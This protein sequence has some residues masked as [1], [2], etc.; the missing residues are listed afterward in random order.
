MAKRKTKRNAGRLE[1]RRGFKIR[2]D[3]MV[4]LAEDGPLPDVHDCMGLTRAHGQPVLFAVARDARTIFASWNIDWPSLFEKV[5]PV[6]R[7]VHLRLYG[8]DGLQEK[9]VAVEPMAMMHYL[10]TSGLH[11]SYRL[12]IGYYQPADAW[13]SAATSQ[14]I[15]MPPSAIGKTADV[16]LATIPFHV[17][18]QQLVNLFESDSKIPL[19]VAI[20]RFEKDVLSSEQSNPLT[21]ADKELLRELGISLPQIEAAWRRFDETDAEK[22]VKLTRGQ[23]ALGATSP[24]REFGEGSWS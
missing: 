3:P 10:T 6:D 23:P 16:D 19:A 13:H 18:F 1:V 9:S 12:E 21:A 14:E 24:S 15:V 17:A 2:K 4:R 8:A 5:L 22:L 7:Q 20:S 11:T